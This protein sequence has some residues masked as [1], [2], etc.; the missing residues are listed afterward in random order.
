MKSQKSYQNEGSEACL[1]VVPTPIGN[2]DD[3][4]FRAINVLK[5]VDLIA[6]EDTRNTKKLCNHF[7]ISKPM[8]S[9]H[10]HNLESAGAQIISR[11]N[12]GE[13]VAI[14]SDAGMPAISDPGYEIVRDAIADG[15]KVI[16]LPG[17]NAA[18]TA[19]V[20]SGIVPQ[21]FYFYGF[22]NRQKSKKR[23]ELETLKS[24]GSTIIFYESP[25]RLKETVQVMAEV[26]GDRQVVLARE[27][28]KK[29]E[30]YL[31][32]SLTEAATWAKETELRGE[33]VVVVEG[34]SAE[35]VAQTDWW[36]DLTISEHVE[37]Y[38]A[39]KNLTPN[40]AMK[41][42]GKDRNLSK[43]DVYKEYHN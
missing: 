16:S 4:T 13:T 23:K 40:E 21:P 20:A 42:V 36:I 1:Y 24:V 35:D 15:I 38:I 41:L 33:F 37:K 32:G 8:I 11:I 34:G 27:I 25:H 30:E 9:Y 5:S 14:V 2:L 29:F 28:S 18:I 17:A 26:L 31:R 19:L 12:N 10:E 39:D 22:L 6:A 43:R 7:E 3:M